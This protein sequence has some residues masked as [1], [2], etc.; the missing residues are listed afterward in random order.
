M[1][2]IA[3]M[4][5]LFEVVAADIQIAVTVTAVRTATNV[6]RY[7]ITGV[8]Q[9]AAM[10]E[11]Q[12][13]TT[14][15]NGDANGG[16]SMITTTIANGDTSGDNT[17]LVTLSGDAATNNEAYNVTV[18]AVL[19]SPSTGYTFLIATPTVTVPA[20]VDTSVFVTVTAMR[21]SNDNVR[22]M[23]S[24]AVDY[25]PQQTVQVDINAMNANGAG[26]NVASNVMIMS[27]ATMGTQ[28][29]D[30]NNAIPGSYTVTFAILQVTTGFTAQLSTT[31]ID[32]PA[33]ALSPV[34]IMVSV[35]RTNQNVITYTM[36]AVVDTALTTSDIVVDVM[37]TNINGMSV[38][39][40]ERITIPQ[41][42]LS[43]TRMPVVT[44]SLQ[45]FTTT[46][47]V[48]ATTPSTHQGELSV[49]SLTIPA[50]TTPISIQVTAM[51]TSAASTLFTVRATLAQAPA[52]NVAA[53]LQIQNSNGIGGNDN[54]NLSFAPTETEDEQMRTVSLAGSNIANNN[55]SYTAT[56][57][58]HPNFP[59]TMGFSLNIQTLSVTVPSFT[60]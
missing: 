32:I 49:T 26:A 56:V 4:G 2:I 10:E 5:Q 59:P 50:A 48:V 22:I 43:A 20:F 23:Y 35:M 42:Q 16:V 57:R 58:Q 21:M 45:A 60:G 28:T 31:S 55:L 1:G 9:D 14:L 40:T 30:I 37:F 47:M 13:R 24:A 3:T 53:T 38:N 19:V 18:T 29:L 36:M 33:I 8:V 11:I 51:R 7:T 54:F 39:S 25:A 6:T 17:V 34:R 46:L 27:T 15:A 12:F 41:G 44:G 52:Q